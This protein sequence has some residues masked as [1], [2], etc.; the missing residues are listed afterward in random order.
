MSFIIL[1]VTMITSFAVV[2]NSLIARYTICLNALC[3]VH[4]QRFQASASHSTYIFVLEQ[5]G[6]AKEQSSGLLRAEILANIKEV[7]NPREESSTLARA[8]GRIIEDAGF[9]DDC[10][11]VVIVGAEA[12]LLFFF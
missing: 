10:G 4:G 8:D 3:V 5:F 7:N 6:G 9:L 11:L 12:A 2:A 1:L